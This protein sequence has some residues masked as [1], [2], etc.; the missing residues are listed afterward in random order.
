MPALWFWEERPQAEWFG[1]V[2]VLGGVWVYYPIIWPWTEMRSY[3][4][5]NGF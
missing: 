2:C 1:H 4:C 5:G 3:L